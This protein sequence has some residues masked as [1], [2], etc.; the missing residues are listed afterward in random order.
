[1]AV[2]GF[3]II[4]DI[5]GYTAFMTG[6]ELEH[7]EDIL[8]SLMELIIEYNQPPLKVSKLEGDAVFS[9]TPHGS[10]RQGQTFV[11][12]IENTYAAF[13]QQLDRMRLNTTCTCR[14][15]SNIVNLDLKFF[16]HY[17]T[18]SVRE[19]HGSEELSGSDVI[20]IHRLLKN[21]I[22]EQTGCKSYAYFTE[23]ALQAV[24]LQTDFTKQLI[25]HGEEYEHLGQVQGYVYS[26]HDFWE[27]R[28]GQLKQLV[29]PQEA[30]FDYLS[31]ILPYPASV[32]W[33]FATRPETRTL[34]F[35]SDSQN[36]T[37]LQSG[38]IAQGSIYHCVHGKMIIKQLVTDWSPFEYY[39]ISSPGILPGVK[40]LFT[41][42]FEPGEHGICLRTLGKRSHGP[43]L[44]R[45]LNDTLTFNMMRKEMPV[46][47]NNL[48]EH[49][50]QLVE[51][52]L[53]VLPDATPITPE[54]VTQAVH[55]GMQS[56]SAE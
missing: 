20:L 38:R 45:M 30:E 49:I 29:A 43:A 48:A 55:Q 5:T 27:K 46:R 35:G 36:V 41:M 3:L 25:Q 44:L 50:R 52:G 53:L 26:L 4:S 39:T 37:E 1:M 24:G 33:D 47:V 15:C 32:V 13:R 14:A 12:V 54:T 7:A 21:H 19:V 56:D 51:K 40:M 8:Q 31:P 2:E 11:E 34:L 17:G 10:F 22:V 42:R 16:V 18:F 23:A 6:S 28:R 9:Y